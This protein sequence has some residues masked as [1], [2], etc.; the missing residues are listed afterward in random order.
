MRESVLG[1]RGEGGREGSE[2]GAGGHK[3]AHDTA[4]AEQ[5]T[6]DNL[7]A[8]ERAVEGS[9]MSSSPGHQAPHLWDPYW[10]LSLPSRTSCRE[11]VSLWFLSFGWGGGMP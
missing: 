4:E 8:P 3:L 9:E 2:A 1:G 6:E 5:L 11:I 10:A 7:A